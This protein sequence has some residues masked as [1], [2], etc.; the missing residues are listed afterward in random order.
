M[1]SQP[2][3]PQ[4]E[5]FGHAAA[6]GN[7]GLREDLRRVSRGEIGVYEAFQTLTQ[8]QEEQKRAAADLLEHE[9][10]AVTL[11]SGASEAIWRQLPG[12]TLRF[13]LDT[14]CDSE[15]SHLELGRFSHLAALDAP[16]SEEQSLSALRTPCFARVYPHKD[17]QAAGHSGALA[18]SYVPISPTEAVASLGFARIVTEIETATR[19]AGH[20]LLVEGAA[21]RERQQ[22]LL[23]IERMRGWE[24]D[25]AADPVA[26]A[27]PFTTRLAMML[28]GQGD[29]S[30][31]GSGAL[32]ACSIN[33][34]LRF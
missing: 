15:R 27:P 28:M 10:W 21:Q 26:A 25:P 5:G 24:P 20:A 23:R 9:T 31:L 2:V 16:S 18:C 30:W 32:R 8:S 11:L 19:T 22:Q 4:G 14:S 3:P 13:A 17:R 1:K 12:P 33:G 34:I 6:N 7:R 29:R